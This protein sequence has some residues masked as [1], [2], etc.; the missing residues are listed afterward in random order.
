[1]GVIDHDGAVLPSTND[2][3]S[4]RDRIHLADAVGDRIPRDA[5]RIGACGGNKGVLHV[6]SP[7]QPKMDSGPTTGTGRVDHGAVEAHRDRFA[8][9]IGRSHAHRRDR[10]RGG[11]GNPGAGDVV[12]PDHTVS[13]AVEQ[14][15]LDPEV[16]LHV[17]VKVEMIPGEIRKH[18]HVEFD[19]TNPFQTQR[20]RGDFHRDSLDPRGEHLRQQTLQVNRLGRRL[21]RRNG[22]PAVAITDRSDDSRGHPRRGKDRLHQVG[23]RSLAVGSGYAHKQHLAAG[24]TVKRS[25]P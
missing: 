24:E 14:A 18:G 15:R 12:H 10:Y 21:Q 23:H 4:A 16:V 5:E 25:R 3:E 11:R 6:E 1:M 20:V 2:L 17:G 19:S 8:A 9:H 7:S 22:A 13:G